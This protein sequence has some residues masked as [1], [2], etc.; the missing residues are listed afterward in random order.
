M[1]AASMRW[2]DLVRCIELNRSA[3]TCFEG[4]LDDPISYWES[5]LALFGPQAVV[6]H[7]LF[8]GYPTQRPDVGLVLCSL[9][10]DAGVTP[11]WR[12][13]Y[14]APSYSSD[15]DTSYPH[16]ASEL[17]WQE[18]VALARLHAHIRLDGFDSVSD[19]I[20][21]YLTDDC[22]DTFRVEFIRALS[23]RIVQS[24]G[25]D[26][27]NKIIEQC[28]ATPNVQ[29][30][31]RSQ[32]ISVLKLGL[33]DFLTQQGDIG[34]ATLMAAGC[35][36]DAPSPDMAVALVCNGASIQEAAAHALPL[37]SLNLG[38]G[39]H[40]IDE[41]MVKDIR[42]WISSSRL[43]A[44][45]APEQ[46][47]GELSRLD[48]EGWYRCWLRFN[49][50]LAKY[51]ASKRKEDD[52]ADIRN[53]FKKLS[54]D[55]RPFSGTPRACDLY[56]L[57]GLILE[58]L[59]WGF[60]LLSTC[61]EWSEALRIINKVHNETSTSL[62]RSPS[63]PIEV[64]GL[65]KLL[66][67]HV[68]RSDAAHIIRSFV[69][70]LVAE[71]ES[72][73]T[74]YEYHAE[75]NMLL[76]RMY[77]STE[78]PLKAQVIWRKVAIYLAGYGFRKDITIYEL[79]DSARALMEASR[80][81]ALDALAKVQPLTDVVLRHTDGK[82]TR[83]APNCWFY[84]LLKCD[85]LAGLELLSRTLCVR[86]A[87]LG[88]PISTAIGAVIK[89]TADTA[90]PELL[91]HLYSVLP[92][93]VDHESESK[94]LADERLAVIERLLNCDL[95]QGVEA[96]N[97][98]V[99]Q[100]GG[101]GRSYKEGAVRQLREFAKKHTFTLP[102]LPEGV[103]QHDETTMSG[104][105]PASRS[106]RDDAANNG[107][108]GLSNCFAGMS[109]SDI[110]VGIRCAGDSLLLSGQ[111]RDK[112]VNALGYRLLNLV[113]N[114]R[115]DDAIRVIRYYSRISGAQY[116]NIHPLAEVAEGLERHGYNRAAA[117]AYALAYVRTRGEGG[118]LMMG[119]MKHVSILIRGIQLERHAALESVAVEI[120]YMLRDLSYHAGLSRH[121]IEC[122]AA[123]GEPHVAVDCWQSAYD[124]IQ[125]RLPTDTG[126][127]GWFERLQPD[128]S[129]RWSINEGIIAILLGC[130]HHPILN[131]KIAALAGVC[132][133]IVSCPDVLA[134]P[135]RIYLS[136]DATVSSTLLVLFA[137]VLFEKSPYSISKAMVEVLNGYAISELW[138]LS[139]LARKLLDRAGMPLPKAPQQMRLE[140]RNLSRQRVDAILTVDCGGRVERLE[141][142]WP[143]IPHLLASRF[144]DI[145]RSSAMHDE[146]CKASFRLSY[147]NDGKVRPSTPLLH[148]H[149]ELFEVALQE[150]LSGINSH[151]WATGTWFAGVEDNLLKIVMPNIVAHLGINASRVV[152]PSYSK[153]HTLTQGL[154]DVAVLDQDPLY[155]NW[156]RIA[157]YE[158]QWV[159]ED[160]SRYGP[161]TLTATI[162]AGAVAVPLGDSP[163]DDASPFREAD[164]MDWWTIRRS[165]RPLLGPLT[166]C[167]W[168]AD[169]LGNHHVLI[170]PAEI[171]VLVNVVP[172]KYGDPIAWKDE[173]GQ[174]IVVFRTW[175]MRDPEQYDGEP[176]EFEGADL[177]MCPDIYEKLEALIGVRIQ[178]LSVK[179]T[180]PL[181]Q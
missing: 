77:K 120:A 148:W 146:R 78:D 75:H 73:G 3:Y 45:T 88:W 70:T 147:G 138:G 174:P 17:S 166:G 110:L 106:S 61:D 169:W 62:Q 160:S 102:E 23:C 44:F 86:D 142:M 71:R 97:R 32:V 8:D 55:V 29:W 131:R 111:Q 46:L 49:L 15:D 171:A 124:V 116:R 134:R 84:N 178:E 12:K 155:N 79:L 40:Y 104:R 66:L 170:P 25:Q 69:E 5:F 38:L 56:Q 114:D 135:L 115:E 19:K 24:A 36:V 144:D 103:D 90:N 112:F 22:H 1:V 123:W 156:R 63:G 80:D 10:D 100:V 42:L 50:A 26:A 91:T 164:I 7:L 89:A 176:L 60:S 16:M 54:S 85:S 179:N 118:W 154:K 143:D 9:I 159:R 119:G 83:Q 92:F 157:Y 53:A 181:S 95:A 43:Y 130:T 180:Q 30:P 81:A 27:I 141:G 67:L 65:L 98:L 51:E 101:D 168:V 39:E 18:R 128:E 99:A 52:V 2:S 145:Y 47:D 165:Q 6:E 125:H 64:E 132:K 173:G 172:P 82:E 93:E 76:A 4:R 48:G 149:Q 163:P 139:I 57:R 108:I 167:G 41:A 20:L 34:S 14:E 158:C 87:T 28:D 58:S 152:R 161:P 151:L 133:A 109:M 175:R 107:D 177:L 21:K 162:Y 11:P 122:A 59:A 137:L 113:Q 72:T 37:S 140:D 105:T 153:P 117:V 31:A 96:F 126:S 129:Q 68:E 35:V 136:R 127:V 13:Y 74:Y 121:I 150:V 94:R 33:A